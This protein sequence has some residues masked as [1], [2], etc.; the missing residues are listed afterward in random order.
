MSARPNQ[1][2][3]FIVEGLPPGRYLA[4]AVDYLEP[5]DELNPELLEQWRAAATS[6]VLAE[7]ESRTLKLQL[8][9]F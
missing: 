6:V 9:P 3:R 4:I 7:G 8:S 5:G 2:G 1:Q